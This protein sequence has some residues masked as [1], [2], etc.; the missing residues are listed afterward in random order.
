MKNKKAGISITLSWFAATIVVFFIILGG[1]FFEGTIIATKKSLSSDTKVQFKGI[2][3]AAVQ[4]EFISFLDS[5]IIFEGKTM[6]VADLISERE[7]TGNEKYFVE[8]KKQMDLFIVKFS[9]WEWF[10]SNGFAKYTSIYGAS[11]IRVYDASEVVTKDFTYGSKYSSYAYSS[12]VESDVQVGLNEPRTLD[13]TSD[14][15]PLQ[16]SVFMEV[17]ISPT[18]RVALC[19][20]Y[21]Q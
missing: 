3:D 18:K 4:R 21:V 12:S 5:E 11:W 14:C 17:F 2:H 13:K 7:L 1:L 16:N 15:N 19:M 6:K 8:F 10:S 9:S 20:E